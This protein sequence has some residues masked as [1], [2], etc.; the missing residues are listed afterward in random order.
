M[1]TPKDRLHD[2][3]SNLRSLQALLEQRMLEIQ[4]KV[5]VMSTLHQRFGGTVAHDTEKK[6]GP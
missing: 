4:T 2:L 3:R 5:Q 6:A 1:S